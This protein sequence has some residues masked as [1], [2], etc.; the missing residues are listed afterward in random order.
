MGNLFKKKFG[1]I[2]SG[3]IIFVLV[4]LIILFS[5]NGWGGQNKII[6]NILNFLNGDSML[7]YV[8]IAITSTLLL[9]LAIMEFAN[10]T[11]S[12]DDFKLI[13]KM[14]II[15]IFTA[16]SY[17]L[18][19]IGIPLFLPFLKLE[20]S[21][22]VIVGVMFIVDYKSAML[23]AFIKSAIDYLI[24]GSAVGYPIDQIA[25][26]IAVS[27]FLTTLYIF[28][29]IFA[30]RD[31][32]EKGVIIGA[33]CG[34]FSTTILML[35]LN[36]LWILPVYM[37]LFTTDGFYKYIEK[38]EPTNFL[39]WVVSIFGPFNLIQWG[40]VAIASYIIYKKVVLTLR[41]K[42]K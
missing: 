41:V 12:N 2:I 6:N 38:E 9:G 20:I 33:V 15:A 13:Q 35:L 8:F 36:F 37:K 16:L 28:A 32:E 30:K 34:V 21:V 25:H 4:T 24:K 42:M 5:V 40:V 10:K 19:F 3:L 31:K 23:I 29:K 18:M 14:T 39:L 27:I 11:K 17:I 7:K 22:A 26:F 1:L